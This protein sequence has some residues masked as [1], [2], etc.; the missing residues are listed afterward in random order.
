M[1]AAAAATAAV[2]RDPMLAILGIA[3]ALGLAYAAALAIATVPN[4]YDLLWYHL[5]R[6]AIWVQE[7]GVH[8]IEHANTTRLNE[9]PPGAEILSAWTMSLEGSDRYASSFQVIG[10]AA[11]MLAVSRIAR[12]VGFDNREAAF[13]ALL[14]GTL[15][16]IV[17]QATTAG[18]DLVMT[19]FVV[20]VVAFM[21][22]DTRTALGLGALALALSV[23][24]KGTALF[25]IPM[26][27]VVAVDPRAAPALVAGRAR[28]RPEHRRGRALVRVSPR[29]GR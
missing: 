27:L 7:H 17:L 6:A 2:L 11:S 13:G 1:R 23:L 24:T 8:Y 21:L 25:T 26:L 22:N 5:P 19:S 28:G 10:L 12:L 4:D 3:V 15:P 9:N 29:R 16:V 14:F 20:T 18:N